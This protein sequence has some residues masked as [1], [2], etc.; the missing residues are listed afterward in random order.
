EVHHFVLDTER[1]VEAALRHA[2]MQRHLAAFEPALELEA[3]ARLGALVPAS[4]RLAV[5]AALAAPDAFLRVLHAFRRFEIA[6]IHLLDL[7]EMA[8]L[9]NHPANS[10]RV[11]QLH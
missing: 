2:P 11:F 3:R 4:R 7:E 8:N 9:V 1:V 6:E 5:A 10:G